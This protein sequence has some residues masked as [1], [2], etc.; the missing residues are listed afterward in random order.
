[1]TALSV[2]VAVVAIG[3]AVYAVKHIHPFAF[4][5]WLT[6][7]LEAP[8]RRLFSIASARA[9]GARAWHARAGDRSGRWLR[10]RTG[11]SAAGAD[12]TAR[13]S[14]R[15]N[16][17]APQGPREASHGRRP[18]YCRRRAAD[19]EAMLL[20]IEFSRPTPQNRSKRGESPPIRHWS[21]AADN[22]QKAFAPQ[23]L[24]A[25]RISSPY[26]CQA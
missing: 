20:R 3:G 10:D 4:P 11:G 8:T 19:R 13:L 1:M 14:R 9:D 2:L 15:S 17:D 18:W 21:L 25:I 23:H 6:P 7:L 26:A 12:W 24:S 22:A 16:W 5:V